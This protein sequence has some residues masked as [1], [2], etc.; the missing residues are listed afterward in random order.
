[1]N[2]FPTDDPLQPTT[3][4]DGDVFLAKLAAVTVQLSPTPTSTPPPTRTPTPPP[5]ASPTPT[6]LPAT[7]EYNE[8]YAYDTIGN[9]TR[10]ASKVYAY[11]TQSGACA[12]GALRLPHAAVTV[13]GQSYC[14]DA[15][16]N[17]L[18]GGGRSY[19]W[20]A[21]NQPSRITHSGVTEQ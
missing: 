11:G 7:S 8:T 6:P 3:G 9:L 14:Y 21:Q 16:G 2:D 1:M 4:G 17:L 20:T 12:A 15:N 10:K 5:T 18:S 19:A 13:D